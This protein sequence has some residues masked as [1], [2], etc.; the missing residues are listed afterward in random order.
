MCIVAAKAGDNDFGL[1]GFAVTVG[2]LEKQNVGTVGDPHAPMPHGDPRRNI[3]PLG[4]NS[5]LVNPAIAV[6]VFENFYPVAPRAG[7]DRGYLQAFE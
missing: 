2:V 3:E 5:H 4:E 1:V 7:S 6:G